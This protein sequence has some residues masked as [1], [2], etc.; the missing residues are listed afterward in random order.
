MYVDTIQYELY[1]SVKSIG[2]PN[3]IRN[4][5]FSLFCSIKCPGDLILKTYDL[6][7]S[8]RDGGTTVISGFHSPMEQ[9]CLRILLKGRQPIIVCPARSID[10]M[11]IPKEW[12][13]PLD[14]E[15]LLIVSPF[16]E[17]QNR[18]TAQ[19]A[20]LRNEFVADISD[21]VFFTYAVENGKTEQLCKKIT[22]NGKLVY[23]F[24]RPETQN[25]IQLGAKHFNFELTSKII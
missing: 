20:V 14:K 2:N 8:L 25:L 6:A 1:D 9:E 12:Q 16:D 4:P 5:K 13:K 24:N 11:R 10:K 7:K 18:T 17:K 19:T 15:R 22:K 21:A 3:L 23:T